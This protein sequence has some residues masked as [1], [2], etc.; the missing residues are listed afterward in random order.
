[1]TPASLSSSPEVGPEATC[2][3]AADPVRRNL[4][5]KLC[6]GDKKEFY[7]PSTKV[8]IGSLLDAAAQLSAAARKSKAP[9]RLFLAPPPLRGPAVFKV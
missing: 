3:E 8:N 5:T 9:G 7:I 2:P 1:M 6:P 4:E